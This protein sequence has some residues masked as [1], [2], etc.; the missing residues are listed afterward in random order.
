MSEDYT[1]QVEGL[2]DEASVLEDGPAKVALL[3]EAVRLADAHGNSGLGYEVRQELIHAA[4]FG[5]YP[6]K[7]LV[8]FTWCLA[9]CD[10]AADGQLEHAMLWKYKWVANALPEFPHIALEQIHAVLDDMATRYQRAGMSLRAV[11]KLRCGL[12]MGMGDRETARAQHRAWQHAPADAVSDCAACERNHRVKYLFFEGKDEEGL[13]HAEP[14]LQGRLRC[15]EIPHATLARVLLPLVRL[16]RVEEAMAY[17]RQGVRLVRRNRSFLRELGLHMIFLALTDNLAHALRLLERHLGWALE[18]EGEARRFD[19]IVAA[20]FVLARLQAAGKTVVRL[21]L[22]PGF[23]LQRPEG[24]YEVDE[25]SAWFEADAEDLAARFD[26]RNGTDWFAQRIRE[27]RAL[28]E[29]VAPYP[30]PARHRGE[31]AEE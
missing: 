17:H 27:S 8:A 31:Q 29:L 9:H 24:K 12:A 6:E 28:K 14:I 4:T 3:E 26:A 21:R 20:R 10:R 13:A 18:K 7:A 23:A 5:G 22:P 2:L 1:P 25:L 15:A 19:F 30:V 16:G 11:Y